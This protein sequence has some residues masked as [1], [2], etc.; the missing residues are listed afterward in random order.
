M[1]WYQDNC[2]SKTIYFPVPP[3][4]HLVWHKSAV[5]YHHSL[6][7]TEKQISFLHCYTILGASI[8][9]TLCQE[10]SENTTTTNKSLQLFVSLICWITLA[11]GSTSAMAL[12]EMSNI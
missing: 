4:S 12:F 1:L 5:L 8:S 7:A 11:S 3:S 10:R 6:I 2:N 9:P